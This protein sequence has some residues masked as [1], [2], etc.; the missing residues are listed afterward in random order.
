MFLP[1]VFRRF[2]YEHLQSLLYV[3]IVGIVDYDLFPVY[4]PVWLHSYEFSEEIP[5]GVDIEHYGVVVRLKCEIIGNRG[6]HNCAEPHT[7][8]HRNCS[9]RCKV[10]SEGVDDVVEQKYNH[11]H[12]HRHSHTSLSDNG[13][14]RCSDKEE[15]NTWKRERHLLPNLYLVKPELTFHGFHHVGSELQVSCRQRHF[16]QSRVYHLRL[17]P[18]LHVLEE[19]VGI[20]PC[21]L[22]SL[23]CQFAHLLLVFSIDGV[24]FLSYFQDVF[25]PLLRGWQRTIPQLQRVEL[26]VCNVVSSLIIHH[27]VGEV[28]MSVQEQELRL[29]EPRHL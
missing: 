4:I 16:L 7:E 27:A 19:G 12:N 1:S 15:N 22:Y 9:R 6:K 25:S 10:G 18:L 21:S 26:Q 11:S 24:T 5:V 14:E 2:L 3:G 23:L 29:G 13:S 20:H 28:V 8:P 17:F